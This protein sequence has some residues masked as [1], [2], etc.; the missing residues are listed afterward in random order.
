MASNADAVAILC[1]IADTCVDRFA[2]LAL[3]G[4]YGAVVSLLIQIAALTPGDPQASITCQQ[5]DQDHAPKIDFDPAT[6][7]H[8]YFCAEAGR[9]DVEDADIAT[10]CLDPEWLVDWLQA[11]IPI[12][13]PV[14]RRVLVPSGQPRIRVRRF[15]CECRSQQCRR[16][17]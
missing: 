3:E 15:Q 14:R 11:E 1:E 17:R 7:R 2:A 9:V 13:P 8:F 16:H 6:A 10:L 5:C 12:I 4:Q